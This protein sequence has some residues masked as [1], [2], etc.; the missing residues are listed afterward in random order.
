M[1]TEKLERF[2]Q[3]Q[4]QRMLKL[5]KMEDYDQSVNTPKY[6]D[7]KTKQVVSGMSIIYDNIIGWLHGQEAYEAL[8]MDFQ[9]SEMVISEDTLSINAP[10]F[11]T[12]MM[13]LVR[14]LYH[15]LVAQELVS[16]QPMTGPS[17]YIYWLSKQ[18]TN[19]HA[20]S[21]ITAGQRLDQQ[22]PTTYVQHSAEQQ[23][24]RAIEMSLERKEIT[25]ISDKLKSDWTLEAEQDWLAQYKLSVEGEMVNEIADEMRR[26]LDRRIFN[27]LIGGVANTINWNPAGYRSG[28]VLISTHR[29]SYEETIYDAIIDAQAWI[30]ANKRGVVADSGIQW[31]LVMSPTNWARFAKLENYNLTSLNVQVETGIGRRFVGVINSLFKIY[32]A[33]EISDCSILL[34]AKSNWLLSP[35]YYAVY[36]A[37]YTSP[38][39]ITNDDFSRFSRGCMSRHTWGIIG[40]TPTGTTSNLLCLINLC[41]S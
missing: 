34:A 33:P 20:A 7:E 15:N 4:K 8:W 13:P 21:G 26:E 2:L 39:F 27:I 3:A 19:T 28:D 5:D 12:H 9:K 16:I 6:Y 35:A 29:K 17:S 23:T 37:L 30:M 31:N 38:K 1:I 22:T 40:E 41:F 14:R 18:Y 32:I 10:T 24:I 25:A 11:T 36:Q